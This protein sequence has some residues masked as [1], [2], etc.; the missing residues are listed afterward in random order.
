MSPP[1]AG[2][3]MNSIMNIPP[4]PPLRYPT[5]ASGGS[6]VVL[7]PPPGPPPPSDA[8]SMSATYIP[9]GET[10]GEGVGIPGFGIDSSSTM[11]ASW[12]AAA[13]QAAIDANNT[14][15][16][17]DDAAARDRFYAAQQRGLSNASSAASGSTIS[18]ELAAQ[19][20]L[21]TVLIWL[22]QNQFSKDWQETFKGLNLHGAQFLELGSLHGGRGNFG[23]MHQKVYPRL[24]QECSNSGTGWDQTR[25]REEGKRMRRLIRSIVTGKPVDASKMTTSH[26]RNQSVN[27]GHAS[28]LPSAGTDPNDSPNVS[29]LAETTPCIASN[30]RHRLSKARPRRAS[31]RENSP[32]RGLR[33]CPRSTTAP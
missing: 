20:S 13:T 27:A 15:N 4:P 8:M 11:H 33:R 2:P 24:A 6:G 21:D 29:V 17:I 1:M 19:W 16:P 32:R 23:M 28:S 9:T 14:M 3:P 31:S 30:Q 10:Y 5:A 18:P 25:E 22:A 26:G 7:P 12:Q